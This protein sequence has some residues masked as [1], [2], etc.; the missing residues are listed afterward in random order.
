M[1]GREAS[2]ALDG[3]DPVLLVKG[4]EVFGKDALTVTRGRFVYSFATSESK[5]EFERNPAS[6]EIQLGGLCARMGGTAGGNG[7]SFAVHEG[8]IY[9]FGSDECRKRF[10]AAPAKFIPPTAPALP[11]DAEA[12]RRG[13]ALIA[14]AVE[15][16]GGAKALDGMTTYV[17][18]ATYTT[19]GQM[20]PATIT[21]VTSRRL[22]DAATR[23]DRTMTSG[24]AT[25]Q[26]A[27]VSSETEAFFAAQGRV[28]PMLE[29]GRPNLTAQLARHPVMMLRARGHREFKAAALG[30]GTAGNTAVEL[31]GVRIGPEAGGPE[32]GK[33]ADV[34]A[35]L[36]IDAKT[37][38]VLSLSYVDRD[39]EGAFG[40]IALVYSDFRP[41]GELTLPFVWQGSVEGKA[42]PA[43]SLTLTSIDVNRPLAA[44]LFQR[45]VEG[46]P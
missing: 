17:E 28:F 27:T 31:V 3:L 38:R 42:E 4:Q 43:L 10:I 21:Q 33:V 8:K 24:N 2:E 26:S 32:A 13:T 41:V 7:N 11:T 16:L 14:R 6:Y 30:S 5:A 29:A 40:T 36:G 18:S 25:R 44:T 45:P 12:A 37:G 1:P 15:A 19:E 34:A 35:T 46:Q 23:I 20:G 39:S 22:T 9:V